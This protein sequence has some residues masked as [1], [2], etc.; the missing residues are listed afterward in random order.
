MWIPLTKTKFVCV[1]K[2]NTV[3]IKT[4]KFHTHPSTYC[5]HLPEKISKSKPIDNIC[6]LCDPKIC[7]LNFRHPDTALHCQLSSEINFSA[8][9]LSVSNSRCLKRPLECPWCA[10]SQWDC[11]HIDVW[12]Q[13][14]WM[15]S[16]SWRLWNSANEILVNRCVYG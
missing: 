15:T 8:H 16:K 11:Q 3:W 12:S 10:H 4:T 7:L 1:Q 2:K 5:N 14:N 13:L 9:T 6:T